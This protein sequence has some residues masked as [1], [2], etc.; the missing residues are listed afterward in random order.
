MQ[1]LDGGD[2]ALL[3]PELNVGVSR[4]TLGDFVS[5]LYGGNLETD[6][7]KMEPLY[8]QR[9]LLLEGSYAAERGEIPAGFLPAEVQRVFDA[10]S[11]REF[12][13]TQ[14]FANV[15]LA[16]QRHEVELVL[17]PSLAATPGV[18]LGLY[19]YLSNPS[20]R[21][22]NR[23]PKQER[24]KGREQIEAV[25]G[26]CRVPQDVAETMLAQFKT[27]PGLLRVLLLSPGMRKVELEG[28]R[29]L[30][31]KRIAEIELVLGAGL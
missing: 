10:K 9:I 17:S 3:L 26:L 8:G 24:V 21:F 27:L 30:G 31:P 14:R 16:I 1:A 11:G 18:L 29:G 13:T 6:L 23:L 5:S 28:V 7:A 20:H 4:K 12:L 22:L 25:M 15:L 19:R 2:F